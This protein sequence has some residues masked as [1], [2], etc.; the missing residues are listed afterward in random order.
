MSDTL[1]N[2]KIPA[3]DWVDIYS[4]SGIAPGTVLLIENIGVSDVYLAVQ[5]GKPIERHT[6]Y[7][8]V[9]R[10]GSP[11]INNQG[12][13][14]VWA[15]CVSEE[16]LINVNP[17][18]NNG[19][20]PK[21]VNPPFKQSDESNRVAMV[22]MNGESHVGFKVDDISV[23]FQY[24][25]SN[26]DIV[27]D[28]NNVGRKT[29][30]GTIGTEGSMAV[31][32]TGIGI[33]EASIESKDAVRYR[34]GHECHAA[35]SIV[36]GP[37]TEEVDQFAG[38]L[39]NS[40]G[41]SVGYNGLV[42]GVWFIEGGNVN[43]YPQADFSIDKLDGKGP[44]GYEINP[45]TG[46]V[47]RLTYTWHGFLDMLLEI[48]TSD[49]RWMPAHKLV[50]VNSA[51]ETHLENPNLPVAV[52][53]GRSLTSGA[54]VTIKTGS[55]RAG[56]I[57]GL[58]ENNASD[59]WFP[60]FKLN[61]PVSA[62][63]TAAAHLLSL[64]SK[65]IFQSKANHIKTLVKI[66]RAASAYNKDIVVAVYPTV[67]L[68]DADPTWAIALDA[69]YVDVD[70]ENSVIQ[71]GK[72]PTV[73]SVDISSLTDTDIADLALVQSNRSTESEDVNGFNIYPQGEISF[74]AIPQAGGNGDVSLQGNFKELH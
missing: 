67:I 47:Y 49:G 41:W 36:F 14:G 73:D 59:R 29:G 4:L 22:S 15:F 34:A 54:N 58:D 23:N 62:N 55:W 26:F 57:S 16:G 46:Q 1:P 32:G 39:N 17:D 68:R 13:L 9:K 12:D 61:Q 10:N 52:R 8:I 50:F 27:S 25:I 31:V 18:T 30:T 3:S 72:G 11:L 21:M 64:R 44:S 28:G 38:F 40:D 70:S 56:V 42:F 51:T 71:V 19:F 48:R 24:G 60:F 65:D 20:S 5:D 2:I 45:Q 74:V 53:I 37:P 69:A 6:A 63:L 7:N 33:G 66:I 35:L 43:F